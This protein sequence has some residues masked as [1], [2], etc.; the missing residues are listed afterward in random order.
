M[1]CPQRAPVTTTCVPEAAKEGFPSDTS[2][3]SL[4]AQKLKISLIPF[5]LPRKGT[6]PHTG[7]G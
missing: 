7:W 1:N 4:L 6:N 2:G 3:I 5:V